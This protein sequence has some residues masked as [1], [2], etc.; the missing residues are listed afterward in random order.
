[1]LADVETLIYD[2]MHQVGQDKS[3][4]LRFDAKSTGLVTDQQFRASIASLGI[5]LTDG[6]MEALIAKY[7]S[8]DAGTINYHD[9]WKFL[10]AAAEAPRSTQ[11]SAYSTA[12]LSRS[13]ATGRDFA[14]LLSEIPV[15]LEDR[16]ARGLRAMRETMYQKSSN[17]HGFFITLQNTNKLVSVDDVIP[18]LPKLGFPANLATE[19][20]IKE[21][22]LRNSIKSP[23]F[24]T[25]AEFLAFFTGHD[26]SAAAVAPTETNALDSPALMN[27][28]VKINNINLRKF[29]KDLDDDSDGLI[30]TDQLAQGLVETGG[31]HAAMTKEPSFHAYLDT[32]TKRKAGFFGYAEFI[33]F[34]NTR[35][36]GNQGQISGQPLSGS[37]TLVR[38]PDEYTPSLMLELLVKTLRTTQV[39]VESMFLQFDSN[40]D[41]QLDEAEF[42]QG[43]SALGFVLTQPQSKLFFDAIDSNHN[44]Y[45]DIAEFAALIVNPN[46]NPKLS[47][48]VRHA[49]GGASS[50]P[51]GS[52]SNTEVEQQRPATARNT[53]R[54]NTFDLAATQTPLSA[55]EEHTVRSSEVHRTIVHTNQG[56]SKIDLSFP[57][58]QIDPVT[59]TPISSPS[60][61]P[62]PASAR[63]PPGGRSTVDFANDH[64]AST[65][66]PTT[67]PH[68]SKQSDNAM[69]AFDPNHPVANIRSRPTP[70][71]AASSIELSDDQKAPMT[72]LRSMVKPMHS[73][74]GESTV[75]FNQAD[76]EI[77]R[78]SKRVLSSPGGNSNFKLGFEDA[79]LSPEPVTPQYRAQDELNIDLSFDPNSTETDMARRMRRAGGTPNVS[80][81]N[82]AHSSSRNE[83]DL[84]E[85]HGMSHRTRKHIEVPVTVSLGNE[86]GSQVLA[87][88]R[89][90]PVEIDQALIQHLSSAIYAHSQRLRH[91]FQEW[92][93]SSQNATLAKEN[94]VAGARALKVDLSDEQ[95]TAL[96]ARFDGDGD[97]A[98]TYSEFVRML[99]TK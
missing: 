34:V 27:C 44:G 57:E 86:L 68:K 96:Y 61:S 14:S 91:T 81:I 41:G 71:G 26:A 88:Y 17:F 94:F 82:L 84:T 10:Q 1:M 64:G 59:G 67:G 73:P 92:N 52:F 13:P 24:F 72:P 11:Q 95:A 76:S 48:R 46:R 98:I 74:G 58:P 80:K 21:V 37:H 30:S 97:D 6:E 25:Y 7:D 42:F 85:E 60:P 54:P 93:K 51:M 62:R 87:S 35:V 99:A 78:S 49:P 16:I 22:A 75:S 47:T 40:L 56:A 15:S 63:P 39:S 4:F 53:G 32:F 65:P 29:F 66:R 70:L 33:K 90:A 69:L 89:E 79:A 8:E 77:L 38:I 23:G 18:A 20:E 83:A 19:E 50:V 28:L 12:L 31:L 36:H 2:R 45:V 5:A 3:L 55:E 9:F 43:V